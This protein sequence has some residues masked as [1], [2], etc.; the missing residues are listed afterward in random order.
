MKGSLLIKISKLSMPNNAD[1]FFK[2]EIL[3]EYNLE[4]DSNITWLKSKEIIEYNNKALPY[5]F[6]SDMKMTNISPLSSIFQQKHLKR[7]KISKKRKI[8]SLAKESFDAKNN[9]YFNNEEEE[10]GLFEY[11][12]GLNDCLFFGC[13]NAFNEYMR[14]SPQI[15]LTSAY[16]LNK[17]YYNEKEENNINTIILYISED[18]MN[19]LLKKI[20]LLNKERTRFLLNKLNP[21]NEMKTENLRFFIST[22]KMIYINIDSKVDLINNKNIFYFVYEAS[23]WEKKKKEIIYDQGSFIGLNNIFLNENKNNFDIFTIYSKAS[24]FILFKID[25]NYLSN[26]NKESMKKFLDNI[27]NNQYLARAFYLSK[28]LFYENKKIKEKEIA[29]ENELI[30]YIPLNSE[31]LLYK[32]VL[33]INDKNFKIPG[34]N[35]K[36]LNKVNLSKNISKEIRSPRMLVTI[37]KPKI[38]YFLKKNNLNLNSSRKSK[39]NLPLMKIFNI[40]EKSLIIKNHRNPINNKSF[41]NHN[42]ISSIFKIIKNNDSKKKNDIYPIN[43][44]SGNSIYSSFS[45]FYLNKNNKRG[46]NK[47]I[48]NFDK[49]MLLRNIKVM[50]NKGNNNLF[51]IYNEKTH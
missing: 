41:N 10:I 35:R 43:C 21:L 30:N 31:S 29:E 28:I 48:S 32:P 49:I 18:K 22:I 25:L 20:S 37:K 45:Y 44:L 40:S 50:N 27:F 34:N 17:R 42:N 7:I 6:L 46:I 1:L 26:N 3:Q 33:Y 51:N 38:K 2:K 4:N 24:N 13:V 39:S 36:N 14:N 23:C 15:H 11:N 9:F 12:L 47:N 8:F 19:K 16:T 5:K